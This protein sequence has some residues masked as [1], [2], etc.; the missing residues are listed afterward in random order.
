LIN[1]KSLKKV[2]AN[3]YDMDDSDAEDSSDV[4]T[5]E[6]RKKPKK[7]KKKEEEQRLIDFLKQMDDTDGKI[8]SYGSD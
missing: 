5:A 3:N 1:L 6:A 2:R 4:G 8:L 7:T